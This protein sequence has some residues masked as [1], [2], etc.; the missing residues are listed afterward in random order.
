MSQFRR[1]SV[2]Y[3]KYRGF[4]IVESELDSIS[5]KLTEADEAV[6]ELKNCFDE[7]ICQNNYLQNRMPESR[8]DFTTKRTEQIFTNLDSLLVSAVEQIQMTTQ[9][10]VIVASGRRSVTNTKRLEAYFARRFERQSLGQ[11]A[12]KKRAKQLVD[13]LCDKPFL[14]P[15]SV[16]CDKDTPRSDH[17]SSGMAKCVLIE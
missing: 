6:F 10:F 8:P 1:I 9:E 17:D 7:L 2:D 13:Q 14:G 11:V 12:A 15:V 3:N 4:K 16:A 5:T